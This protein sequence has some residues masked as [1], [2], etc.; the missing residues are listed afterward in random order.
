MLLAKNFPDIFRTAHWL[1]ISKLDKNIRIF[2]LCTGQAK[3]DR[4]CECPRGSCATWELDVTIAS[5]A[6]FLEGMNIYQEDWGSPDWYAYWQPSKP[7]PF[8]YWSARHMVML[9]DIYNDQR[10]PEGTE[11]Y[12]VMFAYTVYAIMYDLWQFNVCAMAALDHAD[13]IEI[14][15]SLDEIV[16]YAVVYSNAEQELQLAYFLHGW[17]HNAA[18]LFP[19]FSKCK[20]DFYKWRC[21]RS[22][23]QRI[24][25]QR[26]IKSGW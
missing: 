15:R 1:S 20:L 16:H 19:A 2:D 22:I 17:F 25:Q 23:D 14:S 13:Q 9:G 26:S 6:A 5:K 4:V 8:K 21:R 7:D 12:K 10:R 18:A 24:R 11:L 3:C